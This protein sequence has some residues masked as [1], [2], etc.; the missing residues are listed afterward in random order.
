MY[1]VRAQRR[2][3]MSTAP[4][5]PEPSRN[6][7]RPSSLALSL[8]ISIVIA[9]VA[10]AILKIPS[11]SQP[12]SQSYDPLGNWILSTIVA[13]LPVIALLGTLAT[14]KFP[15]HH[16]ALIGLATALLVAIF[17]FHMPVRLAA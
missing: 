8:I 5:S 14:G 4:A 3:S 1:L 2:S 16:S 6:S 9:A 13:A 11:V 7:P 17:A 12:W 15:A 10:I